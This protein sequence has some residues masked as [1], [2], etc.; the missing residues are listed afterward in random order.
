LQVCISCLASLISAVKAPTTWIPSPLVC[1]VAA[2]ATIILIAERLIRL[3]AGN[4][5]LLL[6][7]ISNQFFFV[8]HPR[9]QTH[10]FR[11]CSNGIEMH[12][13]LLHFAS[14][15]SGNTPAGANPLLCTGRLVFR[16]CA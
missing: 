14:D 8:H 4:I 12:K 5:P 10:L 13:Q 9:V 1:A 11:Y 3:K 15:S 7:D 2:P 6:L 16:L